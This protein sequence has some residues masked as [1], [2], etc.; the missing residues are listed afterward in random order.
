MATTRPLTLDRARI[1]AYRRRVGSLDERQPRTAAA[2]RRAAW[3]GLQ[4]SVPRA[5]V[6]ALHARIDHVRPDDWEHP[7]LVQLWGPRYSVFVVAAEDLAPFSLGTLPDDEPGRRRAV[8]LA[9]A[10]EAALGGEQRTYS[11]VG[12][13]LGGNP[14]MLR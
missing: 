13:E 10:L 6:L 11:A 4:D 5:A 2:I 14:N 9:D 1:L 12:H 3:A 7:S 8:A